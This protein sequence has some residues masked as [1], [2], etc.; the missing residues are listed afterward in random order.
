M[1]GQVS[2][3]CSVTPKVSIVAGP[4]RFLLTS[5]TVGAGRDL[6]HATYVN[7]SRGICDHY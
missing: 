7:V 4:G 1:S 2:P 6:I 3:I 5:V